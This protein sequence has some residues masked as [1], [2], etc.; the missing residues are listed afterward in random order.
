MA[1]LLFNSNSLT[2]EE[3]QLRNELEEWCKAKFR[4]GHRPIA[5]HTAFRIMAKWTYDPDKY[6][7]RERGRRE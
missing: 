7:L 1:N 6:G 5:L 2:A 4:K 3:C